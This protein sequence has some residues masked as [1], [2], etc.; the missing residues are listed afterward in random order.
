MSSSLS[1]SPDP[2]TPAT[3]TTPTTLLGGHVF[4]SGDGGRDSSEFLAEDRDALDLDADGDAVLLQ[5]NATGKK[6]KKKKKPKKSASVK[7]R[8]E[9]ERMK[10]REREKDRPPVLCISRNKHWKYISSYHGPWLQLPLELLESLLALNLDPATLSPPT[11]TIT[12]SE[13]SPAPAIS[14]T[15][16]YTNNNSGNGN[17]N[18]NGNYNNNVKRDRE[19]DRD[20]GFHSLNLSSNPDI[21]TFTNPN[22]YGYNHY[23]YPG[24]PTASSSSLVSGP[25]SPTQPYLGIGIGKPTPPPI[26]P[27]VFQNVASIRR[28]IDEAAEL[29]VRASSGM[30]AAEL[31]A[32]GMGP[33]GG[34]GG[35]L[36]GGGASATASATST[37]QA[38]GFNPTPNGHANGR[39]VAM[40]AMRIHRLRALA[41]QKLAEAYKADE[42]ASS[43]MVMQGGSV[44]DDLAERVLRFDP[45]DVDARYVH[46]FH[47]KIPSRQLAESTTT[48]TLDELILA[49]PQRLEFYR[50]RGIVHCFKDEYVQATKDFTYA[51]KEARAV[52]KVKMRGVHGEAVGGG[53]GGGREK[54]GAPSGG[55]GGKGKKGKKGGGNGRRGKKQPQ[56]Q[57]TGAGDEDS[58]EAPSTTAP[59]PEPMGAAGPTPTP[60]PTTLPYP[61]SPSPI[62]P[63]LLFLR[64][65]AYLSHAVHIVESTA[66]ELE[67]V[68]RKPTVDGAELRLS[69]LE[70][71]RYG[72]VEVGGDGP[73]G[74]SGGEKA[75]V[76]R[77][78]FVGGVT[79]GGKKGI[80]DK[81]ETLLRKSI[82][83]HE[84]FLGHFDSLESGPPPIGVD[85][86]RPPSTS[87]EGGGGGEEG[88][89][90]E[91]EQ[92][93]WVKECR[94]VALLNQ[95]E[96][97]FYL[98]ESIRPGSHQ[99][100][101]PPPASSPSSASSFG[102]RVPVPTFT[103]YHPLLV[104]SHFSILLCMLLLGDFAGILSRFARTA[105]LVD[106]LEGYPVFLPPRSMAQAEFIEVLERLAGGWTVGRVKGLAEMEREREIREREMEREGKG[107]RI[108][109]EPEPEP[110]PEPVAR[111]EEYQPYEAS[112][113][114][115]ACTSAATTPRSSTPDGATT[116]T[117]ASASAS[118][119]PLL[120]AP[121]V[122]VDA[123]A[124]GS[125]V[126]PRSDATEALECARILL[127]PV[128]ARQREQAEKARRE[129]EAVRAQK[130]KAKNGNGGSNPKRGGGGGGEMVLANG[131]NGALP[132]KKPVPIN[133]P[134]H[135][136]RVEVVLAWLG[137]VVL[138]EIEGKAE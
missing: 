106:G 101:S 21:G 52:R 58:S 36:F 110:G 136:P 117:S 33:G 80:R 34:G 72:G 102:T 121:A 92:Y 134:L 20:R 123:N 107:K 129:R 48:Q 59:S 73:L 111:I 17:G 45:N 119:T 3:P 31:R 91:S 66:L 109:Y 84:R 4:V 49:Q 61:S 94:H 100:V 132:L 65:A 35:G 104:E 81:V 75:R 27:G 114:S 37:A 99:P 50:T 54:D 127:A 74:P 62:E 126:P 97:A 26:D 95:T 57:A 78:T 8:E 23:P 105:A 1:T 67:G 87:T 89:E 90:T 64:G 40:S 112:T 68:T 7:A 51:L 125:W 96:Y 131:T 76:Y 79:V 55:G 118:A 60:H 53:V 69:Y 11:P 120:S 113:S 124:N 77:E 63:Q 29:S 10:E 71:G 46:F 13:G 19:R 130:D 82:R 86:F 39:N 88:N 5:E 14:N 85:D 18:G 22:G 15:P 25:P 30:S 43:V 133:I 122:A 9:S 138:P 93:D 70:E 24:F 38:L 16:Y 128:I 6:K 41:V 47:E 103:T 116:S 28:L 32:S 83:D 115:S 44:F 137:G 56:G 98:S 12:T 2:S 42:I 135:G 108:E